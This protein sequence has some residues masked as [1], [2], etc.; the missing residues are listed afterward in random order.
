MIIY[1]NFGQWEPTL[2]QVRRRLAYGF[3]W[4]EAT[5]EAARRVA[6]KSPGLHSSASRCR[7]SRLLCD[8]QQPGAP[9]D[10]LGRTDTIWICQ[11][12]RYSC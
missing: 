5:A 2:G 1:G 7:A 3:A 6:T 4:T 10:G 12:G 11:R 9:G 8:P